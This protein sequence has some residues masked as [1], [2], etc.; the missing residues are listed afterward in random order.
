MKSHEFKNNDF[1]SHRWRVV[2]ID[3][4]PPNPEKIDIEPHQI[5]NISSW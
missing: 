1:E 5:E 2:N 4:K 3:D